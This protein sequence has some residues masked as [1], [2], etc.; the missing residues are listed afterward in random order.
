MTSR[1]FRAQ[2]LLQGVR[3]AQLLCE[4]SDPTDTKIEPEQIRKNVTTILMILTETEDFLNE[5]LHNRVSGS[6]N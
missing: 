2:M 6:E 3:T 4:G 1:E 5:Y